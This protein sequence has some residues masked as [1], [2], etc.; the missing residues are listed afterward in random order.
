VQN[1]IWLETGEGGRVRLQVRMGLFVIWSNSYQVLPQDQIIFPRT[2]NLLK[3]TRDIF[4]Y[5]KR[6]YILYWFVE[7]IMLIILII[8]IFRENDTKLSTT[9][10]TTP[11]CR[12]PTSTA[13]S[14]RTTPSSG[15]FPLFQGCQNIKKCKCQI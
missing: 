1:F 3:Y 13:S 5:N 10:S 11:T 7:N 14:C 9:S 15:S 8:I 2:A 4:C 6:H 12:R